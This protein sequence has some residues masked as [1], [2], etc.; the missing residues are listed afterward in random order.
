[1]L[2]F[3]VIKVKMNNSRKYPNFDFKIAKTYLQP[4]FKIFDK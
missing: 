2:I 3:Y 1:M 4:I